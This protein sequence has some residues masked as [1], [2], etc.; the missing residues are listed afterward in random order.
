[1]GRRRFQLG[2][3]EGWLVEKSEES[4]GMVAAEEEATPFW[5]FLCL[6]SWEM[7]L[8]NFYSFSPLVVVCSLI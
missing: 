1:M 2:D 6:W 7:E 8:K 3:E 5:T 4:S